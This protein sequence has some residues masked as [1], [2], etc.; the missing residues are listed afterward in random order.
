MNRYYYTPRKIPG[1]NHV[2]IRSINE[3]V[4]ICKK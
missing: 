1:K 2:E 3:A 4:T